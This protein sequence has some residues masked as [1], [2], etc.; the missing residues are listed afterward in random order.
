[1]NG[2]STETVSVAFITSNLLTKTTYGIPV[3][4][5]TNGDAM[6][7]FARLSKC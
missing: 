1:M 4:N 7:E 3:D 6:Y 5:L 2:I